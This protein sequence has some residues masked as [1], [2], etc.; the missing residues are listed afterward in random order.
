MK[1][2]ITYYR[3]YM[4]KEKKSNDEILHESMDGIKA[5]AGASGKR[6]KSIEVKF[7]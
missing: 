2:E 7:E 4:S 1:K 5:L 6:I 3:G